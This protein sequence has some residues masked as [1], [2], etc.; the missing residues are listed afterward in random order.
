[1]VNVDGNS[2]KVQVGWLEVWPH[3]A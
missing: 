1:M 3:G 2:L